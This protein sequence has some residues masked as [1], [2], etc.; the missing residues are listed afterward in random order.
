MTL[1]RH[2]FVAFMLMA[3]IVSL[4]FSP[5][6]TPAGIAGCHHPRTSYA[7]TASLTIV[8]PIS[9]FFSLSATTMEPHPVRTQ[10]LIALNCARLC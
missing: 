10:N 4:A 7:V 1:R 5:L 3:A 6:L 8:L 2:S 9:L